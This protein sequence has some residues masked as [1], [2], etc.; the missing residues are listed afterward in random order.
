M[1]QFDIS[2]TSVSSN[3][4]VNIKILDKFHAFHT[5]HTNIYNKDEEKMKSSTFVTCHFCSSRSRTRFN[6]F[7]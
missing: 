1:N 3:I 4:F 7:F 6:Y 2:K 5:I